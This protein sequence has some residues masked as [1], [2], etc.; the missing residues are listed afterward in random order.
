MAIITYFY[1]SF[2]PFYGI[3]VFTLSIGDGL[4]P[5]ATNLTSIK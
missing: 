2:L 4:A 5:L 1:P 3:G